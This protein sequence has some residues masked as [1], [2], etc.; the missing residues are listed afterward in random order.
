MALGYDTIVGERTRRSLHLL[1][2]KPIDRHSVYIGKFLGAFLSIAII[3]LTVATIGYVIVIGLSGIVPSMAEVGGAYGGI[4]IILMSS[5]IWILFVMLF[6]TSFKTVT[7]TIIFSF[8]FWF[9]ILQ[10]FSLSGLIYYS[11]ITSTADEPISVDVVVIENSFLGFS[12]HRISE[13]IANVEV[14]LRDENGSI[15]EPA[16]TQGSE[17]LPLFPLAGLEYGNYTWKAIYQPASTSSKDTIARGEFYYNPDFVP[18][19]STSALDEDEYYNDFVLNLAGQSSDSNVRYNITIT[20]KTDNEIIEQKTVRRGLY[21]QPNL[22][23]GDYRIEIT[24]DNDTYLKSTLHS[25]GSLE[26]QSQFMGFLS[27]EDVEY[28][29]YVKI[30]YATN[31]DNS[32]SVAFEVLTGEPATGILSTQEGLIALAIEFVTILILGMLIFSR[33]ELL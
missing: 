32:A 26:T 21:I 12:S 17:L 10:F 19:V 25:Y 1:L 23:E 4:F 14:E 7:S 24:R 13:P 9:I 16:D 6:S 20:S 2:S 18:W 11:V 3:Y 22:E 30:T 33:I 29:D 8:I 15:I 28:P 5:A 27:D 31:P